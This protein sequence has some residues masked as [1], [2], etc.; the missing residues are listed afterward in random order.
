MKKHTLKEYLETDLHLRYT[1]IFSGPAGSGKS[2]MLRMLAKRFCIMYDKETFLFTKV[3]DPLGVLSKAGVVAQAGA[4][5]IT[6]FEPVSQ[7][8]VRL[9]NEGLKSLLDVC[10][11]GGFACR[12]SQAVL[13]RHLPR[14]FGIN[15]STRDNWFET[16][17]LSPLAGLLTGDTSAMMHASSD[18]DAIARRVIVFAC[19][20]MLM[21][22]EGIRRLAQETEAKAAA[23]IARL[24]LHEA[25]R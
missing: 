1:G 14:I 21:A 23:G 5:A 18:M 19:P 15:S 4:L 13:Q 3:L 9:S 25:S 12:Y 24:R 22:E 7:N 17:H 11:G 10:E 8:G 6:D 2:T 16:H 20:Q